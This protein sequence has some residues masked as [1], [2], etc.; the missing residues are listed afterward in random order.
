MG[1]ANPLVL[2]LSKHERGWVQ[3]PLTRSLATNHPSA[4]AKSIPPITLSRTAWCLCRSRFSTGRPGMGSSIR[5]LRAPFSDGIRQ[6]R[7]VQSPQ[8]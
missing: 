2:S 8:A 7:W 3:L 1:L 5:S 6:P 4:T